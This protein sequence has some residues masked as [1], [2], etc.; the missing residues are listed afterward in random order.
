MGLGVATTPLIEDGAKGL[1][2]PATENGEWSDRTPADTGVDADEGA[3]TEFSKAGTGG[4]CTRNSVDLVLIASTAG[5]SEA[6]FGLGDT[7]RASGIATSFEPSVGGNNKEHLSESLVKDGDDMSKSWSPWT[8]ASATALGVSSSAR[9][10]TR[11]SSSRRRW[12]QFSSIRF[13]KQ[14]PILRLG[15]EVSLGAES[16]C[17]AASQY[18]VWGPPETR[19][20]ATGADPVLNRGFLAGRPV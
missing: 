9:R 5:A 2:K 6:L 8:S 15:V 7:G 13:L 19:R 3:E 12:C 14:G 10:L 16:V 18:V 4:N 11:A 1:G 17:T 20:E